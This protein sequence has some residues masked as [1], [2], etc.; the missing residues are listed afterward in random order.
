M[1]MRCNRHN[2]HVVLSIDNLGDNISVG[3]VRLANNPTLQLLDNWPN[4]SLGASCP[5]PISVVEFTGTDEGPWIAGN[6]EIDETLDTGC[7]PGETAWGTV[8]GAF[9]R[10]LIMRTDWCVWRELDCF[11]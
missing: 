3:T 5:P 2:R 6:V 1:C 11:S 4:S 10:R 7:K 9:F 8:A